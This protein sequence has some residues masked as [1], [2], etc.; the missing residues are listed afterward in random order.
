MQYASMH[1]N[2]IILAT[3]V[4]CLA[5][6]RCS[7]VDLRA[8]ISAHKRISSKWLQSLKQLWTA[9][10]NTVRVSL[11]NI[12]NRMHKSITNHKAK[13]SIGVMHLHAGD[14]GLVDGR[15]GGEHGRQRLDQQRPRDARLEV[16]PAVLAEPGQAQQ[17]QSVTVS[18]DRAALQ[19]KN[20]ARPGVTSQSVTVQHSCLGSLETTLAFS[21]EHRSVV[22]VNNFELL[23]LKSGEVDTKRRPSKMRFAA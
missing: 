9:A 16:L 11:A 22:W 20:K 3:C 12:L 1:R 4:A 14:V 8:G 2:T 23:S 13:A 5:W 6:A 17:R 15:V 18:H 10:R 7:A 19:R 21:Q